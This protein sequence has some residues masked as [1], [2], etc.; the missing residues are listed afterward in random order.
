[1][2]F[3]I[4]HKTPQENSDSWVYKWFKPGSS[5][6]LQGDAEWQLGPI[7]SE[8]VMNHHGE[9]FG[10]LTE[11]SSLCIATQLKGPSP[12]MKAVMKI[13]IQFVTL[14]SHNDI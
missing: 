6:T 8:R 2:T 7:Q 13:K 5:I 12:G 1:M 4:H 9:D 10:S 11:S 14:D 3:S